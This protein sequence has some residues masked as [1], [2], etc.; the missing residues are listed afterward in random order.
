VVFF[1]LFDFQEWQELSS[2]LKN[3]FNILKTGGLN[4]KKEMIDLI[5][6]VVGVLNTSLRSNENQMTNVNNF[7][8][9]LG[10]AKKWGYNKN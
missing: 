4:I 8:E 6:R 5:K 1:S 3:L 10:L 2:A 7:D 9:L